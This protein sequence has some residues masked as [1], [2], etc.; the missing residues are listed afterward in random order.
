MGAR[1]L[2]IGAGVGLACATATVA[3]AV[4]V[5]GDGYDPSE[6]EAHVKCRVAPGPR[7]PSLRLTRAQTIRGTRRVILRDARSESSR[8]GRLLRGRRFALR[9]PGT[10]ERQG[11]GDST[12]RTGGSYEL[13][14]RRPAYLSG[15]VPATGL[16][17]KGASGRYTRRYA[18]MPYLTRVAGRV[19][20]LDVTVDLR[21][22]R[23]EGI[24]ETFNSVPFTYRPVPGS[25]PLGKQRPSND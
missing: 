17:P 11:A 25:C 18:Y 13:R 12:L 2:A 19:S 1:W 14:F 9:M 24:L 6:I 20:G 7:L 3:V 8:L 21:D 16:P 4:A 10:V 15:V 22:K 5:S 23:I